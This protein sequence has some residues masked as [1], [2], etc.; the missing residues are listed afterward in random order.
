MMSLKHTF[1]S[2]CSPLCPL[3]ATGWL[4][5]LMLLAIGCENNQQIMQQRLGK[6]GDPRLDAA[7]RRNIKALGGLEA[8][9]DIDRI[10][11]KAVATTF[12]LDGGKSLIEQTHT[13]LPGIQDNPS[14]VTVNSEE[15]SG[16]FT[17]ERNPKGK[18]SLWR[19]VGGERIY[20]TAP[21]V[22]FGS[23]LKLLLE[24]RAL[25]GC[26][27]ILKDN[28]DLNYIGLER[29][30]GRLNH[31]I[32]VTG[33]LL[34]RKEKSSGL[35]GT[36]LFGPK[37]PRVRILDDMLI[38]WINAKTMLIERIWLRYQKP[39]KP[40]EFGY[41]AVNLADFKTVGSVTLPQRLEFVPSDE[42]QH[43]SQKNLFL[44]EFQ[45]LEVVNRTKND[46]LN[47]LKNILPGKKSPAEK[48]ASKTE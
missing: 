9:L 44:V 7:V 48:P 41:M 30:G 1:R 12:E 10:E 20:E 3:Q 15:P 31:K 4:V 27:S 11:G 35:L 26:T 19:S 34:K 36:S 38:Y 21:E 29:K 42:Y 39:Y 32:E 5:V 22:L 46:S 45:N 16:T 47:I 25:T 2:L 14:A 40:N 24:G 28:L 13:I 18:V 6:L 43:F 37:T 23:E 17:E 33:R 8:W